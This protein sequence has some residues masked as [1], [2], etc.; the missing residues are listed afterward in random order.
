[1]DGRFEVRRAELLSQAQVSVEDWK[2][3]TERLETFVEPFVESL[4][5][6]AQRPPF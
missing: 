3:V 6:S 4:A 1:M 2:G 5:E